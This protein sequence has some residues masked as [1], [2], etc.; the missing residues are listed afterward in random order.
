MSTRFSQLNHFVFIHW[1]PPYMRAYYKRISTLE[2]EFSANSQKNKSTRVMLMDPFGFLSLD[3]KIIWY[4]R[5]GVTTVVC[6]KH[7]YCRYKELLRKVNYT[8]AK[9]LQLSTL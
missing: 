8:N 6:Y 7:F 4:A 9:N 1:F 2:V 5:R 3:P